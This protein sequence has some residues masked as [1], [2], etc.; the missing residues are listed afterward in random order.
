MNWL[1]KRIARWAGK[2]CFGVAMEHELSPEFVITNHA[3][4]RM[5]KR[6][7]YPEQIDMMETVLDAWHIGKEPPETFDKNMGHKPKKRYKKLVYK[8]HLEYIFIF[9]I[10]DRERVWGGQKY[11][12][13]VYNWRNR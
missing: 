4:H 7:K 3:K 10:R 5:Q 8:Y 2:K 9:A 12:V 13:T 11:L 1:K 6:L